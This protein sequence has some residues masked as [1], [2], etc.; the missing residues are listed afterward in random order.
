MSKKRKL[1]IFG[2]GLFI[3]YN[4]ISG[5][6]FVIEKTDSLATLGAVA[7]AQLTDGASVY[8]QEIPTTKRFFVPFVF[9]YVHKTY[10]FRFQFYG[11]T[12][13]GSIRVSDRDPRLGDR[14]VNVVVTEVVY[15]RKQDDTQTSTTSPV[16][17][18]SSWGEI[19]I[20]KPGEWIVESKGYVIKDGEKKLLTF[21]TMT[22]R[23]TEHGRIQIWRAFDYAVSGMAAG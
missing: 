14:G 20:R 11:S 22:I 8:L 15:Y 18:A 19:V 5:G 10:P 16:F 4:I 13:D 17:K 21:P 3:L 12:R 1:A 9:Y 6:G 2:G 7:D 23:Q